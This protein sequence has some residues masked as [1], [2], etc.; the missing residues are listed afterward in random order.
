MPAPQNTIPE[1]IEPPAT[2]I[3]GS[4]GTLS[5]KLSASEA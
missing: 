4:T 3:T 1:K 5:E 2:S